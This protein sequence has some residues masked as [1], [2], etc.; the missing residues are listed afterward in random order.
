[1]SELSSRAS[2]RPLPIAGGAQKLIFTTG[3]GSL[4]LF[5]FLNFSMFEKEH[6]VCFSPNA[7]PC[8]VFSTSPYR[9]CRGSTDCHHVISPSTELTYVLFSRKRDQYD[10]ME[11]ASTIESRPL[12]HTDSA[13]STR[14]YF[15]TCF[16]LLLSLF[17]LLVHTTFTR[18]RTECLCHDTRLL[19]AAQ[20]PFMCL[21]TMLSCCSMSHGT[22]HWI[23]RHEHSL[24]VP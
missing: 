23:Y 22:Q 14:S 17:R 21:T 3:Q 8:L 4:F 20:L 13:I 9:E 2:P 12:T 10:A 19:A 7:S 18:R 15:H 1:M 11:C 24:H 6:L 16:L 5:F